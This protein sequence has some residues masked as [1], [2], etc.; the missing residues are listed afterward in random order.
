[1]I[2]SAVTGNTDIVS[3]ATSFSSGQKGVVLVNKA[4]SPVTVQVKFQYFTPGKKFYYYTLSGSDDNGEFSRKV[5]V[6]GAGPSNGVAGGPADSYL[7]LKMNASS[8][9]GGIRI[10]MPGRSVVFMVV[11]KK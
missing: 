2:S 5:L 9:D 8:T 10:T 11:D 1:M 7:T 6:N 3:F 4:A